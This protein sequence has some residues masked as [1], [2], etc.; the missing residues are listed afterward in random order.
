MTNVTINVKISG[1]WTPD[2]AKA[3]RLLSR[4]AAW[5]GLGAGVVWLIAAGQVVTTPHTGT[6]GNLPVCRSAPTA[7]ASWCSEVRSESHD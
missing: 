1:K 7:D 4:G 5:I 3:K 2:G 6:P